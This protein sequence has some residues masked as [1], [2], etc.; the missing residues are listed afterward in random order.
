MCELFVV[1]TARCGEPDTATWHAVSVGAAV[2]M[3][4]KRGIVQRGYKS[5]TNGWVIV[6]NFGN[7][8]NLEHVCN[9]DIILESTEQE[10]EWIFDG[11]YGDQL[12]DLVDNATEHRSEIKRLTEL[13]QQNGIE[14][15]GEGKNGKIYNDHGIAIEASWLNHN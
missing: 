8:T 6:V 11:T 10:Q 4:I 13:V 7:D 15:G 9:R 2:R 1:C 12:L 3:G 5:S 14:Y